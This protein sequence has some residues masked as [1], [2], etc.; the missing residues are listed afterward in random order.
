MNITEVARRANVSTATVSRALNGVR[1]VDPALA[2]RAR[3]AAAELGYF[4][5]KQARALVKGTSRI[6]GIIVPE[7]TN[8]FFPAVVQS[9]EDI[10]VAHDY[11]V[12]LTS[13]VSDP[14]RIEASVRRMIER[15]VDGVAV[16]TFGLEDL[17]LQHL[18]QCK[19][20][21]VFV[22]VMPPIS[23]A[24]TI[25][26]D[27]MR[28]IR[29]A[30]Q[31]LAALRHERIAF[32]AGPLELKSA[33]A[34]KSCFE[35]AMDELGLGTAAAI[36][37]AGD[38]SIEGGTHALRALLQLPSRPTAVICSNDVTAIGVISEAYGHISIP[39][40]LSLIG[41]DD[42]HLSSFIT[43]PLTTIRMSQPELGRLS[44]NALVEDLEGKSGDRHPREYSLNTELVLRETTALAPL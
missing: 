21:L 32:V 43:P 1:T 6:L 10:A 33:A 40:Q 11:E 2:R 9:F 3:R 4:P 20:P 34:R 39:S 15:R 31:H 8:P 42:I 12:L 38:H 5:N 27:Y 18:S 44:F 22:D 41:F 19:V 37:V 24:S 17:L 13:T 26:V 30:V 36:T 14:T 29:Q 25:R 7:I 23:R 35:E 28:G 16:L